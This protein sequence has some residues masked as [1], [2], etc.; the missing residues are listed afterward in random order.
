MRFNKAKCKALGPPTQESCRGIEVD[1]EKTK[2]ML[3]RQE[4]HS[5]NKRRGEL[6]VFALEK[7]KLWGDFTE[8]FQ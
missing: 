1:S 2:R 7:R 3:R 5:N 8:A 4:Y 6:G